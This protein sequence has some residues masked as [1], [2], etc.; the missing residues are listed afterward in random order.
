MGGGNRRRERWIVAAVVVI[1]VTAGGGAL[2]ASSA[3]R[4]DTIWVAPHRDRTTGRSTFDLADCGRDDLVVGISSDKGFVAGPRPTWARRQWERLREFAGWAPAPDLVFEYT[5]RIRRTN[6]EPELE[7]IA[8][9]GLAPATWV[10]RNLQS[11]LEE[12]LRNVRLNR[13]T[14]LCT[15]QP[16]PAPYCGFQQYK[17]EEFDS[18]W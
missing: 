1:G 10:R 12:A 14:T 9:P 13:G 8:R 2:V 7:A 5:G 18:R 4:P 16:G 3:R 6:G 15:S 17:F 11:A